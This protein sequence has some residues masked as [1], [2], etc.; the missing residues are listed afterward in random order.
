MGTSL[1]LH[2]PDLLPPAGEPAT[3]AAPTLAYLLGRG[4]R[5][6]A[7]G[8]IRGLAARIFALSDNSAAELPV[9]ALTRLADTGSWESAYCLRADPVYL[10]P[11]RDTLVLAAQPLLTADETRELLASLNAYLAE[12]NLSLE[13]PQPQRW[14]L[15]LPAAPACRFHDLDDAIGRPILDYMPTGAD[16]AR[17]K[18]LQNECQMLLHAHSVNL[19]R[20]ADSELPVNGLWLWGGGAFAELQTRPFAQV[21]SHDPVLAGLA[22][23]AGN[24]AE[25]E[26][27]DFAGWFAGAVDGAALVS[28]S[29]L[30]KTERPKALLE[31]EENWCVPLRLALE[32]N[33]LDTVTLYTEGLCVQLK[34]S[35]LRKFWRRPRPLSASL[36]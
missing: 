2:V 11:D 13:A 8:N 32:Q 23:L 26:P 16:A 5:Q 34:R 17:F 24:E 10:H 15:R 9:A 4:T 21:C 6:A 20:Q 3:D 1:F 22:M 19:K 18:Q 14:Y 35:D 29:S 28:V 33:L 27:D 30:V 36:A 12:D 7:P 25:P 31:F